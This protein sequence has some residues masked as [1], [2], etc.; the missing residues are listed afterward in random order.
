V[1]AEPL[2]GGCT[3]LWPRE[4]RPCPRPHGSQ[5]ARARATAAVGEAPGTEPWGPA[6]CCARP[7]CPGA[8]TAGG[9]TPWGWG[10]SA[11][12]SPLASVCVSCAS[13]EQTLLRGGLRD[14]GW[15]A[16]VTGGSAKALCG[17][18]AEEVPFWRFSERRQTRAGSPATAQA[19]PGEP[20][21]LAWARVCL[22][23]G[24][25]RAAAFPSGSFS[26]PF[27]SRYGAVSTFSLHLGIR[28]VHSTR[29]WRGGMGRAPGHSAGVSAARAARRWLQRRARRHSPVSTLKASLSTPSS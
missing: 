19:A 22:G 8:G 20:V 13:A 23:H 10:G 1:G 25:K 12:A 15:G 2:P 16:W 27:C 26:L 6:G 5:W 28:A 29:L 4:R 24:E 7:S 3:R 17:P 21:A 11:G 9:D 14:G 18:R